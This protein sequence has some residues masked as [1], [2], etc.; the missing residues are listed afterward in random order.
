M[1]YLMTYPVG[2]ILKMYMAYALILTERE[3]RKAQRMERAIKKPA[4][5]PALGK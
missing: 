4:L 3:K 2:L 1:R 5:H